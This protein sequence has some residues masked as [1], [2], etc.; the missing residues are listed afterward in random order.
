MRKGKTMTYIHYQIINNEIINYEII[1][2]DGFGD[3]FGVEFLAPVLTPAELKQYNR[4]FK[5][6]ATT[7]NSK[8]INET[9]ENNLD[10]EA[11]IYAALINPATPEEVIRLLA[12]KRYGVVSRILSHPFVPEVLVNKFISSPLPGLRKAVARNFA[13]PVSSIT[14]LS[15]DEDERVRETVAKNRSTPLEVLET[16][17]GDKSWK[18]RFWAAANYKTHIEVLSTF[19]DDENW[20][21]R[22]VI[23][24]KSD[25]EVIT[26]LSCLCIEELYELPDEKLG[27]Y[28]DEEELAVA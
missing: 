6:L 27:D 14:T 17:L 20:R 11:Y 15:N 22:E 4:V 5:K 3:I 10:D 16:L 2:Y 28:I 8:T 18:V 19:A 12:I 1:K 21:V 13:L 23:N 26:G 7:S 9:I 24:R 25:S